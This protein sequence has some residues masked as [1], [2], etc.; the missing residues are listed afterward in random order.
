VPDG[1][2]YV[3]SWVTDDLRAC[4]QIM[5]ATDRSVEG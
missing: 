4:Y 5:D 1:V 2:R 3:A